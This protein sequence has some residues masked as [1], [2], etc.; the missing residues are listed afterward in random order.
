[1][2]KLNTVNRE[3]ILNLRVHCAELNLAHNASS[4]NG[5]KWNHFV[6]VDV[7]VDPGKNTS[8]KNLWGKHVQK[9]HF[10]NGEKKY[11]HL[12]TAVE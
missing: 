1:M 6:N 7:T 4:L 3:P 2:L 11:L 9:F 5:Q 12:T 10:G 8:P